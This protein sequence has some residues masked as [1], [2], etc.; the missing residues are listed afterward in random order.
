MLVIKEMAITN[1]ANGSILS[2]FVNN[3]NPKFDEKNARSVLELSVIYKF[4]KLKI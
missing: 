2:I 1:R 4:L 3:L